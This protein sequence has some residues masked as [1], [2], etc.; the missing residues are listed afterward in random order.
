MT[1]NVE[2]KLYRLKSIHK[3]QAI[4][5][6]VLSLG[7]SFSIV[8]GR[9]YDTTSFLLFTPKW[10][11][12]LIILFVV[13]TIPIY[14]LLLRTTCGSEREREEW[15]PSHKDTLIAVA[16]IV[17]PQLI[18]WLIAWPGVYSHDAPYH[19]LQLNSTD[20]S[21]PVTDKYSVL[22]TLLLGGAVKLGREFGCVEA[23][24]SCAILF[25]ALFL[26]Y[27]QLK[28]SVFVG[29]RSKSKYFFWVTVI[30]FSFHPFI[31]IMGISSCQ[32]TFFAAFLLLV[33]VESFKI[34]EIISKGKN[35]EFRDVIR[36]VIYVV[37]M[38]LMRNN[39]LYLYAFALICM[40]PFFLRRK[41][42]K[43]AG[44]LFLPIVLVLV[45]I[46][47]VYKVCG[48]VNS[49]TG[50]QEMSSVPSQQLVRSYAANPEN[51]TDD[52][53]ETFNYFY[54]GI[55]DDVSWYWREQEISDA[56]KNKL[57]VPHVKEDMLGYVKF[58]FQVG[59]KNLGNYRDAFMMNTLG[60]WYPFKTYP[61]TK[62]YHDYVKYDTME[63]LDYE[64]EFIKIER[65][66]VMPKVDN[67][68]SRAV[69]S[70]LWSKIPILNL[71]FETGTYTWIFFILCAIAILNKRKDARFAFLII[72]GL[73]LTYMLSPLCY[74]RYSFA[75]IVCIP[76]LALVAFSSELKTETEQ[77]TIP[78][79]EHF[80]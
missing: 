69:Y 66:S 42:F 36:L 7:L 29:K 41:V 59:A 43:T 68:I 14:L 61:D 13:L 78:P 33:I 57:N 15:Q 27:A 47:P 10:T 4:W 39:G 44:L 31:V 23:A 74:F 6:C 56:A 11:I 40:A 54:P 58:Y 37:L 71:I 50:I 77:T 62:M 5:A 45:V 8:A 21:V 51:F 28:A 76:V 49:Q 67:F 22:Y 72:F 79:T 80:N 60:W 9:L 2:N 65:Q 26:T 24:F 73:F 25:Q 3:L 12:A 75:M 1:T 48:V 32:D 63:K 20:G 38:C 16:V 70:G 46:G 55:T 18:F 52:E 19:V 34:G 35:V 17:V 53:K 64:A 30:F